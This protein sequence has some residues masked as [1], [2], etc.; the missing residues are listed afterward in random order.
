MKA[1]L[2]PFYHRDHSIIE[3]GHDMQI[4]TKTEICKFNFNIPG[5]HTSG[6]PNYQIEH[7]HISFPE[8]YSGHAV[9]ELK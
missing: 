6:Q 3:S 5:D 2:Q 8:I 7:E 9:I 4:S 1:K